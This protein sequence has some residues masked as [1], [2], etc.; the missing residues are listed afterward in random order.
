MDN[1]DREIAEELLFSEKKNPSLAKKLF[2]G[3]LDPQQ[4]FPFPTVSE[5]EKKRTEQLLEKVN[6]FADQNIDPDQIDRKAEIPTKVISGLGQLGV[7]GMTIP[8]RYGGLGMTQ[9]A[10]CKIME[11]IARRCGSTALFINAHQSIGLKALLLFGTEEQKG[12][13]L[14]SLAIGEDIAAFSLTEESAGSDANGVTTR[15][16]FDPERNLYRITGKKQ[17]TTNGSLAK[18]LTVMAKTEV[19]TPTGK[20]DKVTAFLV[21]PSMPGFKVAAVGLEKVGMRGTRT[22][23]LEFDNLEVP[24]ANVLGP[25]GGGLKI[26]LT[27]L[28]YGRTTFGAS[29][30]GTA[31]FLVE[32]AIQHAQTRYQFKRPLASFALVK[33]KIADISALAFAMDATTYFTAGMIDQK[34]EDFMLE[35]AILKVFASDSLWTILYETMQIFGGR[36]FFTNYPFERMMRDARLNMI[37]E[38]SNEVMRAFIG[39]VGMRDVG[40]HLQEDLKR[41]KSPFENFK[42]TLDLAGDYYKKLQSPTIP[43]SKLLKSEAEQLSVNVR[44][45]GLAIIRLLAKEREGIIE[46]QLS[47]DRITNGAIALYTTTAVLSKLETDLKNDSPSIKK[48]LILGKHYFQMA[49]DLFSQNIGSIFSNHDVE[50]EDVSDQLTELKNLWQPNK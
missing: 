46:K 10:Y 5:E 16:I 3:E 40:Q 2:F 35:S 17:W 37:G 30:T 33:K 29:C 44:N 6:A 26:C 47:L 25:V 22:S 38:G 45:F 34:I 11:S 4:V 42:K 9:Y 48:D 24:A 18:V 50:T 43:S 41:L 12:R 13:W 15:A 21:T 1:Q 27:V 23:N 36:S 8:Q 39:L 31:K 7:L 14:P 32:K 20:Q 28:D 19:D 49:Q